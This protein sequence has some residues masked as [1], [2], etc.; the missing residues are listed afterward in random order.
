[1]VTEDGWKNYVHTLTFA[2]YALDQCWYTYC[3]LIGTSVLIL[4]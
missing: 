3:D 2:Y 1:M 4:A